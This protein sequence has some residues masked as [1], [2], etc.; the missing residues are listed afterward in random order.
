V[1]AS[2]AADASGPDL[3]RRGPRDAEPA[4]DGE[5]PSASADWEARGQADA[6]GLLQQ[7][8]PKGSG[9]P[10][11]EG[12]ADQRQAE[13]AEDS[14]WPQEEGWADQRQ[15]EAPKDSG[16]PQEEGWDAAGWRA[17]NERQAEG[18]KGSGW[19]R[20]E[21]WADAGSGAAPAEASTNQRQDTSWGGWGDQE[22]DEGK[23]PE[24]AT[25]PWNQ[26]AGTP[27]N[28]AAGTP[29]NWQATTTPAGNP[30]QTSPAEEPDHGDSERGQGTWV[31]KE[32]TQEVKEVKEVNE[33]EV[34]WEALHM[35]KEPDTL[36]KPEG[37]EN[38]DYPEIAADMD[39]KGEGWV[40][41]SHETMVASLLLQ[42]IRGR[43]DKKSLVGGPFPSEDALRVFNTLAHGQIEEQRILVCALQWIEALVLEARVMPD[44]ISSCA[45]ALLAEER[46]ALAL[47]CRHVPALA[48]RTRAG[49]RIPKLHVRRD[50]H[51]T[52]PQLTKLLCEQLR[53][54]EHAHEEVMQIVGDVLGPMPLTVRLMILVHAYEYAAM[55]PQAYA[56]P[57]ALAVAFVK[58]CQAE[59]A[60]EIVC[61]LTLEKALAI[62][63][64]IIEDS[65]K[66]HELRK[67][68]NAALNR[69]FKSWQLR[70]NEEQ[71]AQLHLLE[72]ERQLQVVL[73]IE[74]DVELHWCGLA[75]SKDRT[76][77]DVAAKMRAYLHFDKLIRPY[78][79]GDDA[80]GTKRPPLEKEGGIPITL[81]QVAQVR[82][83]VDTILK[84]LRSQY[85]WVPQGKTRRAVSKANWVARLQSLMSLATNSVVLDA[86]LELARLLTQNSFRKL[87]SEVLVGYSSWWNSLDRE[88]V[89]QERETAS[90]RKLVANVEEI[91]RM[92]SSVQLR[93]QFVPQTPSHLGVAAPMPFT[94]ASGA[95]MPRHGL[96]PATPRGFA[97]GGMTPAGLPPQT[98][99]Q[100]RRVIPPATPLTLTRQQ[101][102][103]TPAGPP[104]LTPG[105]RAA[106]T[107]AG[108]GA[109]ITPWQVKTG[110][111]SAAPQTPADALL[112]A[113]STP[114]EFKPHAGQKA[115]HGGSSAPRTPWH[116]L[117]PSPGAIPSTPI[118]AFQPLTPRGPP[119]ATP[120]GIRGAAPGSSTS[121]FSAPAQPFTPAGP[122]PQTPAFQRGVA[123]GSSTSAFSAPVQPFTPAG[124]PPQ[125]PAFQRGAAPGSSTSAF[126]A[127][128]Q[129]FTPAGPPPQT[130]ANPGSAPPLSAQPFTPA[131]PPPQTPA[132]PRSAPGSAASAMPFTPAGP[133]PATPAPSSAVSAQPFTP[134][135]P[136]PQTPAFRQPSPGG[137]T[138]G[139]SSQP[140]PYTPAGPPPQTPAFQPLSA[141]PQTPAGPPPATPALP[142][143][144]RQGAA[145]GPAAPGTPQDDLRGAAESKPAP[146]T[147]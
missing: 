127:P 88:M 4:E 26:A 65:P 63:Q 120:A 55:N 48:M 83:G 22:A 107:F 116:Q 85:A 9:W 132:F 53:L 38:A 40:P 139:L 7:E 94:P 126:S 57:E 20:E 36:D 104:P 93:P 97:A 137:S 96:P 144:Q 39:Y 145:P 91:M 66:S 143:G 95:G 62:A 25:T 16:W 44:D 99:A 133:P 45:I 18:P 3:R 1:R 72:L 15:A 123:P 14:G 46:G 19:P 34:S 140:Q 86:D 73:N 28:Q 79:C 17:E 42:K 119:P 41:N 105:F 27:G 23:Q 129:P 112:K 24:A 82:E 61:W 67:A 108:A 70:P 115:E 134:A 113:P 84:R 130:P 142:G 109:P 122:P 87:G 52:I 29:W 74:R 75:S 58:Q 89:K 121:A 8:A 68:K 6:E 59:R 37:D 31:G 49:S 128:A 11:E 138:S 147:P 135:G 76:A 101:A 54:P 92:Y 69:L 103:G 90:K 60:I 125:T 81:R 5:R 13:A 100:I 47:V 21:G 50:A 12:W 32:E 98:P 56:S 64:C 117:G 71:A 35:G 102:S 78:L 10:Q 33:P 124:P 106:A 2:A 43:A 136:P 77:E 131:G 80:G 114:S 110:A 141:P 51:E 146:G 118:D 30:M 111:G